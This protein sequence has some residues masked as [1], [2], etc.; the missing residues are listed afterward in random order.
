MNARL[1][2][3]AMRRERLVARCAEQRAALADS[4]QG[5]HA[6][7]QM[8][9]RALSMLAFVRRHP[10]VT[11]AAGALAFALRPRRAGLWLKRGWLVWRLARAVERWAGAPTGKRRQ[12][13]A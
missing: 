5:L 2:E 11:V 12:P 13:T 10:L 7:L 1:A 9:D 6:P 4:V 8:A 3:L